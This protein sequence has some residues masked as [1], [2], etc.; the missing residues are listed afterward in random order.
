MTRLTIYSLDQENALE[1]DDENFDPEQDLRDYDQVAESLPV[2]CVSSRAYQKMTG[3]LQKDG[4]QSQGYMTTAD[5][6][7]PQLQKHAKKLTEA[8]RMSNSRQFLNDLD[9]LLNSMKLWAYNDG[10][11]C[12]LT[13]SEK[14]REERHLHTLLD[15]LEK[16]S[17][18]SSHRLALAKR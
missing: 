15:T 10:N 14:R 18:S 11:R 3:K 2:F 16:V 7:I 4:F 13:D 9:Q 12:T 5:T 17:P 6:E 1:E 8:G